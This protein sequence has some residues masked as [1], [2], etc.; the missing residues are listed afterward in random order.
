MEQPST[1]SRT[2]RTYAA[3]TE[4]L[5]AVLRA[6][7]ADYDAARRVWNGM[8]DRRP[9]MIVRCRDAEEVRDAL[10]V[11]LARGLPVAVRGGGHNAAGLGVCDDGLVIDLSPMRAVAVDPA[12]RTARV[13]GGATWADVDAATQAHGLATTGGAISTTGVGGLTLGGG[14]GW[15]MRRQGLACDNVTEFEV[16]TADGRTVRASAAENADL[17]W[18]LR[19]GGGN[20]G[21]VTAFTFRLLPLRGVVS[22]MLVHPLARAKGVLRFCRDFSAGAPDDLTV[23]AAMMTSPEGEKILALVP[24]YTGPADGADAALRTLREF[25]PPVADQV[26]PMTYVQLQQMLD[27][28]FPSGMQVYWRGEF[29]SGLDDALIDELVDRF[30]DAT[31]PLSAVIL[32]QL[33]GAVARVPRD[34]TAFPHRDAAYNLAM[35]GRWTDPA[36]RDRHVGWVRGLHDAIRPFSRGSSYVNYLGVG[37]SADRV[38]EAYGAAHWDRL[39]ALKTAWDPT[40]VFRFN[41]NVAPGA[42]SSE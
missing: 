12:A 17:F 19:G 26:G 35:V 32:E 15:L 30:A 10:A 29:L 37:E 5:G 1:A 2:T 27:P 13:E 21:I 20:F 11:A 9:A 41:Q 39:V 42:A 3:A 25:G 40:N 14:I 24:A 18:G 33:G 8:I 34:A 31:S 16:V 28:G 7:D 22:G 4:P 23:F 38:R 6:G 36:E